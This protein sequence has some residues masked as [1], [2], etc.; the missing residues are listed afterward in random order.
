MEN[1]INVFNNIEFKK[2]EKE[3]NSIGIVEGCAIKF[4][5]P[6][7]VGHIFSKKL[8]V[9]YGLNNRPV[10]LYN[11]HDDK[12]P[13]ASTE[14]G[15]LEFYKKEDGIYFKAY[16]DRNIQDIDNLYRR[17]G[18]TVNGVSAGFTMLDYE[19]NENEDLVFKKIGVFEISLTHM[20]ANLD[21]SV[22]VLKSLKQDLIKTQE[23]E[24]SYKD[25]KHL[26]K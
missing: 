4:S 25:I 9:E 23:K 12:W 22:K 5:T 13:C 26:F 16:L 2:T 3:E 15:T 21:T 11:N 18:Q 14:N 20:P 24:I 17:V 8:K 1:K 7:F 19:F 10:F 6:D